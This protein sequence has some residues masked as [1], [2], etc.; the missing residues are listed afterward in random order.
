MSNFVPLELYGIVFNILNL[1][2]QI[3]FTCITLFI[4]QQLHISKIKYI[5]ADCG[6]GIRQYGIRDLRLVE[7]DASYNTNITS[8][9]HMSTLTKLNIDGHSGVDQAGI[10]HLDLSYLSAI[11]NTQITNASH[12]H[13]FTARLLSAVIY[14][15]I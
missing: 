14:K 8:L 5:S 13:K 15:F 2:S 10:S 11:D 9:N 4:K 6:C 1:R 3:N 12:M 7:L